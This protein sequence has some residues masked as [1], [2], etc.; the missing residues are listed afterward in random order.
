MNWLWF[1]SLDKLCPALL[2]NEFYLITLL[3]FWIRWDFFLFLDLFSIDFWMT[4]CFNNFFSVM[5]IT[6]H[7]SSNHFRF[8]LGFL[9]SFIWF[10]RTILYS[11]ILNFVEWAYEYFPV[12]KISMILSGICIYRDSKFHLES[13][14]WNDS[15]NHFL[16]WIEVMKTR[17]RDEDRHQAAGCGRPDCAANS[18]G[19][20]LVDGARRQPVEKPPCAPFPSVT[21]SP[22]ITSPTTD[23]SPRPNGIKRKSTPPPS[24]PSPAGSSSPRDGSAQDFQSSGLR[25]L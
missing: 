13:F 10:H 2:I 6:D 3:R 9:I 1:Q 11:I 17:Y 5:G 16:A 21:Q 23:S 24:S 7:D 25:S 19:D 22:R 12:T 20:R 8:S 15:F 18:C 14:I 4:V